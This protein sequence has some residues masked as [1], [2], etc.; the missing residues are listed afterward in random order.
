M[1]QIYAV[2]DGN[3][4]FSS[5]IEEYTKRL[6]KNCQIHYLKPSKKD[7]VSEIIKQESANIQ[8][9]LKQKSAYKVLLDI[10]SK[11]LSTMEFYKFI[12]KEKQKQTD[13]IFLI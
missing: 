2:S 1:I 12:E 11:V 4:H 9:L 10:E 6:G 5:A 3:K 7:T 8:K 13:I